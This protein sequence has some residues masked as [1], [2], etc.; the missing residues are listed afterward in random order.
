MAMQ[1][2]RRGILVAGFLLLVFGLLC[3][4]Y[5]KA[6]GL[7]RHREVARVHGLPPPSAP[8]LY[9]GVLAV[10]LGAGSIGYAIG[11]RRRDVPQP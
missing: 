6:D 11:A 9:G 1:G 4:N 2:I 5:T 10:I 8:I 3:L 7:A